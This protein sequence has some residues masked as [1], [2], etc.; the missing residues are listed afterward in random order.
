MYTL[1]R[2]ML[3]R[4]ITVNA[5]N[6][7]CTLYRP[8]LGVEQMPL[9]L[10]MLDEEMVL[11]KRSQC[12]TRKSD[13][14]YVLEENDIAGRRVIAVYL[15][16]GQWAIVENIE[17]IWKAYRRQNSY[18]DDDGNLVITTA[19]MR[20]I[21]NV[22]YDIIYGRSL[23]TNLTL[24]KLLLKSR[25]RDL[26]G[27]VPRVYSRIVFTSTGEAYYIAAKTNKVMNL[28][29]N[30]MEDEGESKK[31]DIAMEVAVQSFISTIE[32]YNIS[33]TDA[34]MSLRAA[35]DMIREDE[36]VVG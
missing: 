17:E 28:P 19:I 12:R 22:E 21:I 24:E 32:Q 33:P 34:V 27:L 13:R 14:F 1:V 20:D 8:K 3:L 15:G 16:R 29:I 9:V 30:V 35:L 7:T 36:S 2:Q 18:F 31:A 5:Q 4:H 6:K 25:K 26:P 11:W 10:R 23:Y